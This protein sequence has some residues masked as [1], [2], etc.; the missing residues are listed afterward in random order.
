M[1]EKLTDEFLQQHADEIFDRSKNW[2]D[3]IIRPQWEA[4]NDQY[5][6]KFGVPLRNKTRQRK[7]STNL[8]GEERLFIPKTYS[9]IQRM[10]VDIMETFFFDPDEIVSIASWKSIPYKSRE[11]TKALLN[12]RLNSHPIDFYQ[13]LFEATLDSLKNKIGILK[14]FPELETMK[15]KNGKEFI[16]KYAPVI[17]C[18]PYEDVF[19]DPNATWKDYYK[20]PI[21]HRMKKSL[22][23]LKRK[24]YKNLDEFEASN[25]SV[26]I[27]NIKQ[28]RRNDTGTPFG[29][30]DKSV[31]DQNETFVYD[32]WTFLHMKDDEEDENDKGRLKSVN[33][34]MMGDSGGPH[35]V[36]SDVTINELPYENM[37][38]NN[39]DNRAPF[40]A[41]VALP[42]PHQMYGK[43]WPELM[44]GLQ[45]ETNAIRNQNREATAIAMRPP[46]LASRHANIDLV[47]LVNRGM[48]RVVLGDDISPNAVRE[49]NLTPPSNLSIQEQF[50]TDSDTFEL[51]SI[52]PNLLGASTPGEE[53]ATEVTTQ[54]VNANKKIA[55]MI[56]NLANTL[57]LP[58]LKMLLRLEQTYENDEFIAL[59][60]GRQLGWK[61]I[62][63]N[64]PFKEAINGDFDLIVN[65]GI[66]KQTQL[67]KWFMLMDRANAANQSTAQL[68]Q[69]G[70][71]D[72][73]DIQFQNPM[74]YFEKALPILGEKNI[75]EFKIQAKAPPQEAQGGAGVASQASPEEE[76]NI[77][78]GNTNPEALQ[79]LPQA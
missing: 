9:T 27:D 68:V 60:T 77:I 64:V 61:A 10:H 52:S 15:G 70:V 14:V 38:A 6:S 39:I 1:A 54:N 47:S 66:N 73:A 26:T 34:V 32:I 35:T 65:T 43:S 50:R 18:V 71:V 30:D 69:F 7:K 67:N 41:G 8:L 58:A 5:N 31:E 16:S 72:P 59:V 19:F 53:T 36:I 75:D 2:T 25:E 79:G 23:Y 21:V 12:Y 17:E 28:Q 33:Y 29:G 46:L 76:G 22:D 51:T 11:I 49:L 24:G 44:S 63:D 37:S 40:V 3:Q 13:E 42:E 78:F 57:V 56:K 62:D 4:D 20:F 74:A 55:Q 48:G 45:R